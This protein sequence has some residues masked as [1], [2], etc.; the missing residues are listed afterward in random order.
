MTDEL[1]GERPDPCAT[2]TPKQ[3][4]ALLNA[5]R[6]AVKDAKQRDPDAVREEP[7]RFL[8][9]LFSC[10]RPVSDSEH[11]FFA[12]LLTSTRIHLLENGCD[13]LYGTSR[14]AEDSDMAR[15][16]AA[17]RMVSRGV[18]AIIAWGVS[19][20]GPEVGPILKANLPTIFIDTDV[21]GKHVGCVMSAN[22]EGIASAVRHLAEQGKHR[23]AHIAGCFDTRPGPDR[24]FGYRSELSALG[25]A[26]REK[27]IEQGDFFQQSGYDAAKKLL[28]QSQPPDAITCSSDAMAIGAMVAVQEAGLRI[29]E[30]IAITGF[31]DIDLAA[32]LIP[33]LTTVRQD[34][35]GM[36]IAAA[37]GVLGMLES[38]KAPEMNVIE[39]DLI[40]RDSSRMTPA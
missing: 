32:S 3:A 23:I 38:E 12:K 26:V 5:Q 14:T 34:I 16:K 21:V 19:N 35:I 29:P 37:E 30:D 1:S 28:S 13:L 18:D 6:Q 15:E 25:M 31:D 20:R 7:G 39:A 4:F 22:I 9:G 8:I 11:P 2:F 10:L 24:L 27:Y 17:E 36:G 33:S 40:V